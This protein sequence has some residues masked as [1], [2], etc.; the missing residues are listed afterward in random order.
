[1]AVRE[2][3]KHKGIY[4]VGDSYYVIYNDGTKK[5]SE[6]GEEYLV[7][8]EKRIEGNLDDALKFKVDMEENVKKGRYPVMQR[9]EKMSFKD[10]FDFYEKEEGKDYVMQYKEKYL[11]RFGERKLSQISRHDVFQFRNEVK[12]TPKKR[13][14][15]EVTDSHV[16]RVLAGLRRLFNFAEAEEYMERSPFPTTPKSKLLYPERKGLRNFFTEEQMGKIIDA[17]P[18]WLK[19]MILTSYYTGMRQ[20]ELL[21]LRWEHVDLETGIIHL[22]FSKTL[23]DPS[24]QGQRIVMQRELIEFFK[25]QSKRSEWVFSKQD[26]LPYIHED[27]HKPFKLILKAL[28]IDAKQYSWKEIRHTTASLM[29]LKGVASLAI[30]DQLRHTTVK[31]TEDFYIGSNVDYQRAQ[32]EKLILGKEIPQA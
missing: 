28:G 18:G 17:S 25:A 22:P 7:R 31:T 30:K 15:G 6:K 29:H 23:K 26:G 24:G 12:S 4:K 32:A 14:G 2:K 27:I 19:P 10:L 21:K 11:N 16:N 3:T 8:R 13:G 20:G 1:M 5:I 9:M